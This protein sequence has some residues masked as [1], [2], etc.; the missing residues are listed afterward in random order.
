MKRLFGIVL[1]ST[2]SVH[3]WAAEVVLD[4]IRVATDLPTI[5]RGAEDMMTSCHSCHSMKYL[6]YHDLIRFGISKQKVDDWR[7]DQPLDAPLLAQ[8]SESDAIQS[9]AKAPPDLSLMTKAREGGANYVYSYLLGYYTGSDG[10]SGNH[11]FPETRMPDPLGIAGVTDA[12]QRSAI[13]SQAHDIVSFLSWAADPHGQERRRLGNYV[14]AYL[15]VLTA[16]L[17]LLKNQIWSRL[18]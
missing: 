16:L 2:L 18:K 11:V 10:M 14:L 7:G 17:Y 3:A 13:Q 5:E 12:A 8:M 1:L 15:F 9:F 6:K 4:K